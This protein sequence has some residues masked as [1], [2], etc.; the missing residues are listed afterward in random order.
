MAQSNDKWYLLAAT[1]AFMTTYSIHDL[2]FCK[3][4]VSTTTHA[5]IGAGLFFV[6]LAVIGVVFKEIDLVD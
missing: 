2:V 6:S 3:F 4:P 1:L 5:L